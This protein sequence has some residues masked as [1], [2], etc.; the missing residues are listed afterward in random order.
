MKKRLTALALVFVVLATLLTGCGRAKSSG[1]SYIDAGGYMSSG[2]VSNHYAQN[3][4]YSYAPAAAMEESL[5]DMDAG[6]WDGDYLYEPVPEPAEAIQVNLSS[7]ARTQDANPAKLI[8]TADLNMETLEFDAAIQALTELTN[9]CGGYF[10]SS[11]LSDQSY[12]RWASY[13]VRVPAE[14]YRTFLDQAGEGCHVLSQREYTEDVSENYYDTAG[15]LETQKTKLSR[16][17]ALLA[18]AKKMEDIISLE[19]AISETEEIIDRLSGTL[20]HYDALVDYSTVSIYIEEVKV[21]EPDPPETFGSRLSAAFAE[22]IQSFRDGL[23]DLLVFL[24][25]SWIWLLA[26]IVVILIVLLATRK[27]RAAAKEERARRKARA[28][29]RNN[30]PVQY[31]IPAEKTEEDNK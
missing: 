14:Q 3:S 19:S 9:A 31:T 20:R 28:E 11:S 7:T 26:I 12:Y 10:E 4:G 8:Y 18:E 22:G 5:M 16:L 30:E 24:A 17:Q 21:Y 6:D 2:T 15:R 13:T 27:A 1:Q 25:Y 29:A 23:G